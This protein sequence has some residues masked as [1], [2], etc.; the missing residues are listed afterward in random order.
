MFSKSVQRASASTVR[1]TK[2]FSSG[3]EGAT[4]ATGSFGKKEKA[5]ENQWARA[6]VSKRKS[7]GLNV[8]RKVC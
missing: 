8:R 4:A 5:V 3:S 6:H 1:M 2:R 7:V